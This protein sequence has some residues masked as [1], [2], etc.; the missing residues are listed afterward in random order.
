VRYENIVSDH[1]QTHSIRTFQQT[2]LNLKRR[3]NEVVP[4]YRRSSPVGNSIGNGD[5][6]DNDDDG[7]RPTRS[8]YGLDY[9]CPADGSDI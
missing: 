5:D 6:N 4:L 1:Q 7:R 8:G 2:L 3:K 9:E